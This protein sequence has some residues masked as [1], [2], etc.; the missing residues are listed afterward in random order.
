[1]DTA[2]L[3]SII[4]GLG[5]FAQWLAWYLKQP[6][7]LFLLLIGILSGPVL[8]IFNPDAVFG[9]LLF[10]MISLGVAVILFEGALTLEFKEIKGHGKTVQLLVTL[11]ALIT[12][13]VLSIATYV[14]FDVDLEIALLFGSLVCVT[15]PTV[16]AP[17]LR[18]VRPNSNIANVLKWEGIIVDPIGA[19]FVVLVYEYIVTG[20]GEEGVLIF[21][22]M[23]VLATAL[24]VIGAFLLAQLIKKNWVPD[25]LRNVFT[26]AFILLL[27]AFSNAVEHESGLLTITILGVAL[28]NWKDFPKDHILEFK[29][30][31]TVLL[32]STLFIVLSARVDLGALISVGFSGLVLLLVAMFVARPLAVFFSSIGSNL[33]LN[34]KLMISWIGPRGIVAAAISSLFAIRLQQSDLKGVELLVPLVFTIIIGTVIVQGLS[35]KTMA[36]LLNVRQAKNNGVLIVGS[37]P[38]AL[39]V[40]KALQEAN[41]DVVVAFYNYDNIAKARMLGLRTYYGSPISAHADTH[42]DL[43]GIGILLAMSTDRELNAL[44]EMHYRHEFGA[45]NIYRLK[46]S[47]DNNR[48]E[49]DQRHKDLQSRWLFNQNATYAKLSSM[50]SKN[51]NVK[52]TNITDTYSFEQYQADNKEFIPLFCIDKQGNITIMSENHTLNELHDFKLVAL[53]L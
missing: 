32:V 28:A 5:I 34:E 1:M 36:S 15:G 26:L 42:L 19:I 33:T 3:L 43:V 41:I 18:S 52:V 39:M 47:E 40:A 46:F 12:I 49:Q 24:G 30:S 45:E 50:L 22:K 10:P 48:R 20:S 17:L 16:I 27:F 37:N 13:I 44:S 51:A 6:S 8:G 7:I 31:L 53:V 14:L 23:A 38:V 25:Y 11:G 29:E 21:L 2:L 4:V 35:A 9:D